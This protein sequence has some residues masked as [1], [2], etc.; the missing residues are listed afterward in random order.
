[1]K[2]FTEQD[3][4]DLKTVVISQAITMYLS[5]GL[6]GFNGNKQD[7]Q[8]IVNKIAASVNHKILDNEIILIFD[9]MEMI[10]I[11]PFYAMIPGTIK[12]DKFQDWMNTLDNTELFNGVKITYSLS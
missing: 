8:E 5:T 3:I 7:A 2:N 10:K 9:I 6:S 11:P 4:L 1:M 12:S